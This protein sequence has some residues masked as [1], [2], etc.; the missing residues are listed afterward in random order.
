MSQVLEVV[1]EQVVR[2]LS[3]HSSSFE[4]FRNRVFVLT[5]SEI[6]KIM[7]SERRVKEEFESQ[8]QPVV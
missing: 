8:I 3:T 2:A 4:A 7:E 1:K 5:Y 6:V